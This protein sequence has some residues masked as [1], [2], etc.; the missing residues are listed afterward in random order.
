MNAD[1]SN[2][3]EMVSLPRLTS[4]M[5]GPKM[6]DVYAMAWSPSSNTLVFGPANKGL[7]AQGIFTVKTDGT[8][9]RRI[10]PVDSGIWWSASWSPDG[11]EIAVLSTRRGLLVMTPDGSNE[12]VLEADP[13]GHFIAWNPLPPSPETSP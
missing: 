10:T 5:G 3:R 7:I 12:Q 2:Q 4:M 11:A 13:P 9:L 8:E 1:G 6:V